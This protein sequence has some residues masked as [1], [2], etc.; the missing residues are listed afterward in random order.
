MN[1]TFKALLTS[2]VALVIAQDASASLTYDLR[3][4]SV[5]GSGTVT[6]TKT[7]EGIRAGDIVNFDLYLLIP[8]TTASTADDQYQFSHFSVQTGGS[9]NVVGNLGSSF[10]GNTATSGVALTPTFNNTA[11]AGNFAVDLNADGRTDVGDT[12]L[13]ATA[14]W[15]KPRASALTPGGSFYV[16]T[17]QLK[18]SS[19]ADINAAAVMTVNYVLP[20]A[21]TI[22]GTNHAL[23]K[24]NN[25]NK[26]SSS[27]VFVIN[28]AVSISAIAAVPE[29]SAFAMVALGALGLVSFR[30]LGLRR[31]A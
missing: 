6:N 9:N 26:T 27:G 28:S 18:V 24:D 20:T 12:N 1:T 16:G 8:D 5:V 29:P 23:F 30:R 15:I 11:Q 14:G 2:A 3:A 10:T 4:V 31:R 19:V 21:T 25:V 22:A 17:L 7:I 13:A